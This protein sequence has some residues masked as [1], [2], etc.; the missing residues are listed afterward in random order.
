MT[1]LRVL[2][3]RPV[4][5]NLMAPSI[6]PLSPTPPAALTVRTYLI[7]D[8]YIS[9]EVK[10]SLF[11]GKNSFFCNH[12]HWRLAGI[13]AC[14]E[15]FICEKDTNICKPAAREARERPGVSQLL[16]AVAGYDATG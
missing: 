15:D 9:I 8:Y 7:L 2:T 16:E 10:S 4:V 3:L 1:C 14:P 6:V 11:R 5:L 12:S 13:H